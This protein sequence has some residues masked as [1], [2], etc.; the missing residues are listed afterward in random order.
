MDEIET[1][2]GAADLG[3]IVVV[4][5]RPAM[6]AWVGR[7]PQILA[8]DIVRHYSE[9]H[10]NCKLRNKQAC[11]HLLVHRCEFVFAGL[12]DLVHVVP[13]HCCYFDWMLDWNDET[14]CCC[15]TN[16]VTDP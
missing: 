16:N 14:H 4:H 8:Y 2:A 12:Q 5:R 3:L 10:W 7:R 9:C 6:A 11:P 13:K 1:I 15:Y